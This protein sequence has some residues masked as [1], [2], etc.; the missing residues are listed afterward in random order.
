MRP[1]LASRFREEARQAPCGPGGQRQPLS[2]KD[3]SRRQGAVGQGSAGGRRQFPGPDCDGRL[4][5]AP[6]VAPVVRRRRA[7]S[8]SGPGYGGVTPMNVPRTMSCAAWRRRTSSKD[9][10]LLPARKTRSRRRRRLEMG[11]GPGGSESVT[12]RGHHV[13]PKPVPGSLCGP[14]TGG[15]PPRLAHG[16]ARSRR[17]TGLIGHRF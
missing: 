14:T 1:G 16:A 12:G 15:F 5:D 2:Q 9:W 13:R 6:G 11:T 3:R 17:L 10:R 4:A 7:G 8:T